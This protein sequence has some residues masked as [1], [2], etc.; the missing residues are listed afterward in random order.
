MEWEVFFQ[1]Y[2]EATFLSKNAISIP[3]TF[4]FRC[5]QSNT[6]DSVKCI[7]SVT[8][9]VNSTFDSIEAW[10]Y[11]DRSNNDNNSL[12]PSSILST[13]DAIDYINII[14]SLLKREFPKLRENNHLNC[15][16]FRL[17]SFNRLTAFINCLRDDIKVAIQNSLTGCDS[18]DH[19]ESYGFDLD[20]GDEDINQ[21]GQATSTV[22]SSLAAYLPAY[23]ASQDPLWEEILSDG[24]I[25]DRS[26]PLRVITY[27]TTFILEPPEPCTAIFDARE[28]RG[29]HH[30]P[31]ANAKG[32]KQHKGKACL[33]K[34]N[35]RQA[36]NPTVAPMSEEMLRAIKKFLAS[37]R[38]TD[39][40]I[41]NDVRSAPT[42]ES[43]MKNMIKEI[44]ELL[45]NDQRGKRLTIAVI[46]RAGH[47]RSV[48]IA[49][50][51]R[52]VYNDVETDHL[53]IF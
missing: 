51:L 22:P 42:Y 32:D 23:E 3:L 28:L 14:E 2:P 31:Q 48:A 1:Q 25:R 15:H 38:G 49:E 7:L 27:G 6:S 26:R 53:T 12:I 16:Q 43:F 46:C 34:G 4:P 9:T 44:E 11:L 30:G 17:Q 45:K 5:R 33:E 24:M 19:N 47:H 41:M 8:L 20:V 21:E 35:N 50:M 40:I 18:N 36:A 10:G 29:V 37:L 13:I 39:P 52:N